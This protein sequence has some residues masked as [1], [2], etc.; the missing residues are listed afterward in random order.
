M[1][2]PAARA[3]RPMPLFAKLAATATVILVAEVIF[4]TGSEIGSTLGGLALAWLA[5]LLLTRPLV[6]RDPAA[7]IAAALACAYALMLIHDPGPLALLLFVIAVSLAALLPRARFGHALAW[8]PRLAWHGVTGLATPLRDLAHAAAARQA[9]GGTQGLRAMLGVLAIPVIGGALFVMLFAAANPL[10]GNA[11]DRIVLPDWTTTAWRL[12]LGV[13]VLLPVWASLRPRG[14]GLRDRHDTGRRIELGTTTLVLSLA[15]FNLIFAAQN[16]LDIL[17]L[18]SGAPLPG[19]VTM[20]DYAHRGAYTLIATALLAALFV[21]V[22]LRPGSAAAASPAARRLVTAWIL[23]NLLL[24][25]SSA[26]RLF[27]YIEAFGMTGLRLAA[28][29]WMAL[30]ATGLALILWRLLRGR[31][32]AWLIN[33]NALALTAVLSVTGV[34]DLASIAAAWN[35]RHRPS[36][37]LCY[38]EQIGPSG[39]VTLAR[40][41]RQT[42]DPAA[43]EAVAALRWH[44]Q[45]ALAARQDD[46]RSWTWRGADRLAQIAA[47][48]GSQAPR[49]RPAPAGR[50]CGRIM[51]P[52]TPLTEAPQR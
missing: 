10:I 47:L 50:A 9:R 51:P 13:A 27:D 7:R 29:L 37:D 45:T 35:M 46:W 44:A 15:T 48:V 11:V 31:S 32:A 43:R 38:L 34:V 25:A 52:P 26:L 2:N 5:A 3:R 30:V 23:Q 21:L 18:W 22:T 14:L 41:E 39:L 4:D 6:R 42:R 24:V 36:P 33:A 16:A 28:L 49:L 40:I 1:T 20:A 8:V 19:G 17:F 12:L